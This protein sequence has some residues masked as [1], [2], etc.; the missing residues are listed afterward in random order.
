MEFDYG[1]PS[2][3]LCSGDVNLYVWDQHGVCIG[4][5]LVG[6]EHDSIVGLSINDIAFLEEGLVE[7]FTRAVNGKGSSWY[8]NANGVRS[9]C[10]FLPITDDG[11]VVGFSLLSTPEAKVFISRA[12]VIFPLESHF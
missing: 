2:T 4:E 10:G 11:H 8:A 6:I 9:F 5:R 3:P 1:L 12:G 7:C